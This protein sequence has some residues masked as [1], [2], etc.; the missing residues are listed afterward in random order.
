MF[1]KKNEK[2]NFYK[3]KGENKDEYSLDLKDKFVKLKAVN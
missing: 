3:F 1:S 2:I